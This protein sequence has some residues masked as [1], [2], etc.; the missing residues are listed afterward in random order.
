MTAL[1]KALFAHGRVP[2]LL[3]LYV[4]VQ[5]LLDAVTSLAAQAKL[6]LTPGTVVRMLFLAGIFCWLIFCRPYDGK[7]RVLAGTG[8]ITAYLAVFLA[9]SLYQGGMS[10][11]ANNAAEAMK[12]FYTLYLVLFLYALWQ[13]RRFLLPMW[14]VG[15]CGAGYC[16]IILI[17]F[18]TGTSFASYNAGF[19]YS[20]WFYSANDVSNVILLSAPVVLSLSLERM[21]GEK[22]TSRRAWGGMLLVLLSVVFSAAF[23]GTKL[24]YLGVFVYLA[25]ALCW[26]AVR[27]LATKDR[28]FLRGVIAALVLCAVLAALYPISPLNDYMNE[29]FVPMSGEDE[30]AMAESLA[31]EGV[32]EADR[33]AKNA[34]LEAAAEGTWLGEL[35]KTNPV[36]G[37]INWI[38]SRRLLYI[39]PILQE[40]LDGGW[41]I[42]LM[43]LGYGQTADY[44]R[45]IHQLV[46]M[47]PVMLLLRHGAVGLCLGFVPVLAAAVWLLISV[48]RK[49]RQ[50]LCSLN[51]CSMLYSAAAALAACVIVGHV[52]QSPS[53]SI[54]AVSVWAQLLGTVC[55]KELQE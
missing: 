21:T 49:W 20:G 18:L 22:K 23:L 36:V 50:C 44:V 48:L 33:A 13:Q 3:M 47:E 9:W 11:C 14:V 31:I 38:L 55:G 41:W 46:E 40:Y 26:F 52:M 35:V 28:R 4:L 25:A 30:E 54:I 51:C 39:A 17:A 1:R 10:L 15:T 53:V 45:D 2:A 34:A 6:P 19:G 32:K 29:V 27:L 42:K 7:K 5:P 12:V 43:G 8:L 16:G 24:V 37:K